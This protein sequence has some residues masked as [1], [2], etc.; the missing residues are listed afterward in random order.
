MLELRSKKRDRSISCEKAVDTDKVYEYYMEQSKGITKKAEHDRGMLSKLLDMV[1]QIRQYDLKRIRTQE[2]ENVN[3]N[4][5]GLKKDW[6]T[7]K[8]S[9]HDKTKFVEDIQRRHHEEVQIY[10]EFCDY[11]EPGSLKEKIK[12]HIDE[13]KI[14]SRTVKIPIKDL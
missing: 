14:K 4:L 11:L 2:L 10:E 13:I 12:R 7:I 5:T 8:S 1:K 9:L 3:M 6:S